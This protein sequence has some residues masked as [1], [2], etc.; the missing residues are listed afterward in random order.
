MEY[1]TVVELATVL[2]I[3]EAALRQKIR[4]NEIPSTKK[5]GKIAISTADFETYLANNRCWE[6]EIPEWSLYLARKRPIR[7][8]FTKVQGALA[9]L[10]QY[11]ISIEQRT[12]KRWIQNRQI[13]AYNLG[14]TY[15]IPLE[16]LQKELT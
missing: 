9:M 8:Q 15:Y 10:E 12:L 3:T 2:G 14:G 13:K 5:E 16:I 1:Y 7:R 4:A 6:F 11:G